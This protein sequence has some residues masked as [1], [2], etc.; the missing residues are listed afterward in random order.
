MLFRSK[1]DGEGTGAVCLCPITGPWHAM[2]E[3]EAS[4]DS[5]L[6]RPEGHTAVEE[7]VCIHPCLAAFR[8]IR[9]SRAAAASPFGVV[10][11]VHKAAAAVLKS[12]VKPRLIRAWTIGIVYVSAGV[13]INQLFQIRQPTITLQSNVALECHNN[14]VSGTIG[15]EIPESNASQLRH[16][17]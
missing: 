9:P 8:W 7:V 16:Q 15:K 4:G 17:C 3:V 2:G 10:G 12:Q 5:H 13:L 1:P 6:G 14:S 11:S